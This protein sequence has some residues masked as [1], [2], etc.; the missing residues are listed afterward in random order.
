MGHL[1]EV[2]PE[3]EVLLVELQVL[4]HLISGGITRPTFGHGQAG[5]CR[6]ALRSVQMET[7]VLPTPRRRYDILGFYDLELPA[8]LAK[9]RGSGQ[10]SSRCPDYQS[11]GGP[12][13]I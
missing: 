1:S 4:D 8:L 9:F 12:L 3:S 6:E 7:V 13:I 10:T 11:L 5:Q 2:R